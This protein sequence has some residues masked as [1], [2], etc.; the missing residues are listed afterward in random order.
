MKT[1]AKL[2]FLKPFVQA[3]MDSQGMYYNQPYKFKTIS[4]SV[5]SISVYLVGAN[6][7]I[8]EPIKLKKV[9]WV[10]IW[11]V[12]VTPS[13]RVVDCAPENSQRLC[14]AIISDMLWFYYRESKCVD[15]GC[16]GSGV[17]DL[18]TCQTFYRKY[19]RWESPSNDR[20]YKCKS[21]NLIIN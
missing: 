2:L 18:K 14:L 13:G 16:R 17:V 9:I 11:V 12:W 10:M 8:T 3:K 6:H 20:R 1:S 21:I 19:L 5:Y 4:I 7:K 15:R